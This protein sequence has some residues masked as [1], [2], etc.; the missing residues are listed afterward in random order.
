MCK[1]FGIA[2]VFSTIDKRRDLNDV[3]MKDTSQA[4]ESHL[5]DVKTDVTPE[6]LPLVRSPGW[7][8]FVSFPS[9]AKFLA[10]A[11][12]VSGPLENDSISYV[13]ADTCNAVKLGVSDVGSCDCLLGVA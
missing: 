3:N 9:V 12:P 6:E 11:Y 13:I 8:G 4:T 7:K 10:T 5:P 2:L 1:Q